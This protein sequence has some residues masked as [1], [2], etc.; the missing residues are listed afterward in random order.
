MI[1][2]KELGDSKYEI[3]LAKS[4]DFENLNDFRGF[5]QKVTEEKAK[6]LVINFQEV[7][8]ID[9]SALGMLMLAKH[10]TDNSQ[11]DLKLSNVQD[12]H[13]KDVLHLVKFNQLFTIQEG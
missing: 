9:S 8:Y 10:E 4:F 12:G 2:L 3:V 7:E 11:C 13:A 1:K 6:S 5:L